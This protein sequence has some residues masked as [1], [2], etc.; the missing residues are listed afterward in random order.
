MTNT[1]AFSTGGDSFIGPTVYI[2]DD[3]QDMLHSLARVFRR[4][5]L[6]AETFSSAAALIES[7]GTPSNWTRFFARAASGPNAMQN[8]QD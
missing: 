4:A 3:E 1:N 8:L 6:H 2:V 7:V 5:G